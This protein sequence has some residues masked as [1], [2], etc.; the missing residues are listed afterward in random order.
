MGITGSTFFYVYISTVQRY[1]IPT[2]ITGSYVF[3]IS[4][5]L[6][7][8]HE[9]HVGEQ[10]APINAF[11]EAPLESCTSINILEYSQVILVGIEYS[12]P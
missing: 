1:S 7:A 4:T 9:Q 12:R 10:A 2:G 11:Y 5:M 6:W 8:L 3:Y